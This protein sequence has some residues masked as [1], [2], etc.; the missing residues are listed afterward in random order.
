MKT[1]V[2]SILLFSAAGIAGPLLRWATWPPG[3]VGD[4]TGFSMNDFLYNLVLL[5]WPTQPLGVMEASVGRDMA[6]AIAVGANLILFGVAG[7]IVSIASRRLTGIATVYVL[8]C[9]MLTGF[10]F[11]IAGKNLGDIDVVALLVAVALYGLLFL[12]MFRVNR[13]A[14]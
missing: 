5:L 8:L 11:W 4:G 12:A 13:W 6:L 14:H 3:R 10:A 7:V 2:P 1:F 9:A